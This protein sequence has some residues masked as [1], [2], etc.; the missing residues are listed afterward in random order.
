MYKMS[1]QQRGSDIVGEANG[2]EA[3]YSVSLSADG[4]VLAIGARLNDTT[5]YNAGHV[6]V[7][8]WNTST[9]TWVQRG[10]DIDGEAENDQSGYSISLSSDGTVVAIGAIKNNGTSENITEFGHVRIYAWNGTAWIQRGT[11]IDGEA[12]MDHSG[13]SISLSSDGTVVAIGAIG[14][15]SSTGH[16]RVYTWNGMGWNQRGIDIDGEAN[17]NESGYSVSLSSDGMVVAIGATSNSDNGTSAGHTRIYEWDEINAAWIQRG[18]DIDGESANDWSGYSVSLSSDGSVVAI[19]AIGNNSSTGHVRVYTWNGMEWAQRGTDIDGEA[20]GDQSGYSV[21]LS[22]NGTIVGIGAITNSGGGI[23]RGRVRMYTWSGSSW[24]QY[25]N[26]INGG[27]EDEKFGRSISLSSDGF[28]VA[29]GAPGSSPFN[30]LARI[31]TIV[32][33]SPTGLSATAGNQTV[34]VSFTAGNNGGSAITNYMYSTDGGS[35]FTAFSPA[36]TTSPVTI[37]GLANGIQYSIQL[38]AL[39][40]NGSSTASGTVTATPIAPSGGGGSG[41][42]GG[43]I[44]CIPA[45]QRILT[46]TGYKLIET[47]KQDDLIQT[48]DG[49]SVPVRLYS[50]T[51]E[52][53]TEET[54]PVRIGATLLLSPMHAFKVNKR[55][56]MIPKLAVLKN[57]YDVK[58]EPL[59][60]TVTYYH[61]ETTNYLRDNLVVEGTV[62]E[63]YGKTFAKAHNLSFKDIYRRS[64]DGPWLERITSIPPPNSKAKN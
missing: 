4:T 50:T 28:V 5:G 55:G 34:Q 38:K 24:V 13:Y 45:G 56:W 19:G 20:T 59:G 7:Y 23:S 60:Q 15:N 11:D 30:G 16:V 49:R 31:Y 39:N 53:T 18:G 27:A 63:G 1:W 17:G 8:V 22:S 36:Q 48:S 61:V 12:E 2:D 21:S 40:T 46:P 64:K 57:L 25:G 6:R 51:I 54:A 43:G 32:P 3:G 44:P 10:N 33:S 41:S 58:Q 52:K 29:I 26:N 47:L 9:S 37:S 42:G 62:V 35:T 14:N